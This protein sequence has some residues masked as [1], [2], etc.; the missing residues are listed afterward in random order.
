MVHMEPLPRTGYDD[1]GKLIFLPA[2]ALDRPQERLVQRRYCPCCRRTIDAGLHAF[3][4]G[5]SCLAEPLKL[6]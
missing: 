4:D 6:Q 1:D 2:S 3:G 5:D